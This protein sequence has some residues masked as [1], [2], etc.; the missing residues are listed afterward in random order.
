MGAMPA[1]DKSAI[2][3]T[4][5]TWNPTTGCSK[6]SPGCDNCYAEAFAL[7][8]QKMGVPR[9]ARGFEFTVHEDALGLPL[10]WK[11]ARMIF[12][13][14]MS[15][16]F[17]E[18]I[19]IQFIDKVFEVIRAAPQ[20][21]YQ[22]LT[23]RSYSMMK[24]SERLGG[25]PNQVWAGVSFENAQYKFRIDHL[26][27]VRAWV[28]FL[29]IEPLLGPVGHIDLSG[30]DWV[31]VGGESGPNFRPLNPDWVREVRDQCTD[32]DVPF[33]F[34]QWGGRTS[35]SGGRMLDGKMWHQFPRKEGIVVLKPQSFCEDKRKIT[36]EV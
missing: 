17:H 24:Y 3:W 1:G 14:S 21:V 34:K 16:L 32:K 9:Y 12:V 33:F 4:N 18:K 26:R 6:I 36:L 25:F 22:I 19:S 31:I 8:L 23:K 10:M 7:R 13:D 20:H 29:S 35:K 2:E 30:I 15:D 5:S 28:R 11:R 27:R